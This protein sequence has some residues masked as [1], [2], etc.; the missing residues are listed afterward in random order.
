M[1]IKKGV[2]DACKAKVQA[3]QEAYDALAAAVEDYQALLA[4]LIETSDPEDE[5]EKH[6][7]V[8]A[9]LQQNTTKGLMNTLDTDLHDDLIRLS[10]RVI[11]FKHWE[12]GVFV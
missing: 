3:I 6:L 11:R 7:L 8:V 2:Y 10:D 12:D 1:A 9:R 4:S 5:S